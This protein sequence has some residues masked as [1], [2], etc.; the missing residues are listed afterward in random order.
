[1]EQYN[2]NYHKIATQ[3]NFTEATKKLSIILIEKTYISVGDYFKSLSD[4]N[5]C[6]LL[7]LVDQNDDEAYMELVLLSEMLSRGEGIITADELEM[8]ENVAYLKM[9]IV[10]V[11]LARVHKLKVNYQNISFDRDMLDKVILEK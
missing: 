2:I 5:L 8:T 10:S 4:K 3:K 11:H 6:A 7:E 9:I 1:M